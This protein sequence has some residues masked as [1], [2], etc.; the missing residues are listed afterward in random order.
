MIPLKNPTFRVKNIANFEQV[1]SPCTNT[2]AEILCAGKGICGR[3]VADLE[4]A[5]RRGFSAESA[6]DRAAAA[7]AEEGRGGGGGEVEV[8]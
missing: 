2:L 7:T 8:G 4:N 3:D 1:S 5:L 6:F